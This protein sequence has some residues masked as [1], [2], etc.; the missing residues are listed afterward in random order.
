VRTGAA[1]AL[2]VAA[3]ASAVAI[4]VVA[5]RPDSSI[6]C[7]RAWIAASDRTGAGLFQTIRGPKAALPDPR[8]LI[9]VD[10]D[11][12][13][14][15]W[16]TDRADYDVRTVSFLLTDRTSPAF[17][18]PA[19]LPAPD[20]VRCGRYR[21]LDYRSAVLPVRPAGPVTPPTPP[22]IAPAD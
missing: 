14:Q 12:R 19:A 20:V 5:A 8:R 22:P 10:E 4:G 13:A 9:Q 3:L 16:L 2:A 21:I 17:R 7:V 1:A 18:V 15:P 6:S 11:L